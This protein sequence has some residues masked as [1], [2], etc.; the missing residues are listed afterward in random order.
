MAFDT[1]R[2]VVVLHGGRAY[3]NSMTVYF[4]DTWEWDGTTWT[5]HSSSGPT[6]SPGASM[7]YDSARRLVVLYG[8]GD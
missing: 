6:V 5:Q 1:D 7:Y 4:N 2:G 3:Q 8:D